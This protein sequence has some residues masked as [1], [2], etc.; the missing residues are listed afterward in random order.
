MFAN[1]NNLHV[2]FICLHFAKSNGFFH[3]LQL[4]YTLF[5][6]KL[7]FKTQLDIIGLY[8]L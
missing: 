7:Y 3:D 2:I 1:V 6:F 4:H 8:I 5:T